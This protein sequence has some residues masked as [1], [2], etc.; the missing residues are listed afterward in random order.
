MRDANFVGA[1]LDGVDM[2]DSEQTGSRLDQS[3]IKK[4]TGV[5][6]R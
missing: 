5:I 6:G 2:T 4:A 1:I 3:T